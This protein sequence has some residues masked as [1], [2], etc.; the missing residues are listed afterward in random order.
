METE[1]EIANT[2]RAALAEHVKR[3]MASIQPDHDL[4]G[5]LGLDSVGVIELLYKLEEAFDLQIPDQDLGRLRTVGDVLMYVQQTVHTAPPPEQVNPRRSA[6][7]P[8]SR[9][10]PPR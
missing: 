1:G 10:K 7:S 6:P 9:K 5:D 8:S 2:I 3:D 4:R